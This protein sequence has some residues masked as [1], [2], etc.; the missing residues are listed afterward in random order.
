MR[1]NRMMDLVGS[2][3]GG[4]IAAIALACSNAPRTSGADSGRALLDSL[5]CEQTAGG[6]CA[7]YDISLLELIA[8]PIP[9]HG[10]RIRVVGFAHFEFEGNALYVHELDWQHNIFKNGVWVDPPQ[11][12]DSLSGHYVLIEGRF[13][14]KLHGHLGGWSGAIDSVTRLQRFEFPPGTPQVDSSALRRLPPP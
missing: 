12:A 1:M 6:R 13:N 4:G 10:R 5:R 2:L 11:G 3:I 14:G 8:N 7:L 9:F